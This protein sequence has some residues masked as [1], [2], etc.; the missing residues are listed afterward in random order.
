[1]GSDT[2]HDCRV[3]GFTNQLRTQKA[4]LV[5]LTKI[6]R[7]GDYTGTFGKPQKLVVMGFSFGSYITHFAVAE[8][9]TIADGVVLTGINY[10]TTGLNLNGLVRSFVP[11]IASIQ[12]PRRFGLLDPGYLTWSDALVQVNT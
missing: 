1:M 12:N 9:P 6:V 7:S 11:R 10:N 4:I 8:N 3:S 2:K 5:E